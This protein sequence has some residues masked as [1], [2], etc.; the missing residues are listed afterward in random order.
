MDGS[1]KERM[2]R[3]V[4]VYLWLVKVKPDARESEMALGHMTAWPEKGCSTAL[5]DTEQRRTERNPS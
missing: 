3:C 2:I 4:F 1:D 5:R